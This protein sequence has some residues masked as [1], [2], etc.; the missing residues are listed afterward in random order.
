[1]L[2]CKKTIMSVGINVT[3]K[4]KESSKDLYICATSTFTKGL[5]VLSPTAKVA[6]IN[7]NSSLETACLLNEEIN[8]IIDPAKPQ[9]EITKAR[10]KS[11]VLFFKKG[12]C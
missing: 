2:L 5:S 1:M 7:N 3:G 8:F 12:V 6:L 11:L 4:A 9:S 10:V